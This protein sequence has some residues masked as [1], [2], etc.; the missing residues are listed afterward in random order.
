MSDKFFKGFT[1]I[2]LPIKAK[3]TKTEPEIEIVLSKK[4]TKSIEAI[5]SISFL[6]EIK[7]NG[8]SVTA[9]AGEVIEIPVLQT[10]GEVVRIL[11]VG[12][13][14]SSNSHIRKASAAIGRKIKASKSSVLSFLVGKDSDAQL[15]FIST[16]LATYIWSQ[17]SGTKSVTP[18]ITLVG[19]FADVLERSRVLVKS[20]W[21]ARDLIQTPANI[22]NPAWMAAQAKSLAKSPTLSLKIRSG[23]QLAEFGGLSAIGNSSAENPPRFVELSYKPKGSKRVPHV[24]L[25]GK[26]ITFDTGGVS[27]KRPYDVMTAMKSD[28]AGAACVLMA[29]IAAAE[30]KLDVRITALLMLAENALSGTSTRPSDVITHYGGTTVEVINTDAEGRL[31]LADGLAY[32]DKNL[33]PDYLIDVAT[34]TGAA[35]LGLSRYYGAM[36]TRDSKLARKLSD[37]GDY[38]GDQVWH[39]PL[40]DDYS[41]ALE[42]NIADFNHTADKFKFQGGSV[43]AALFLENFVGKRK[44]VHLDIAGPARSEV[45]AGE[46]VKGGTGYGVRLLTQWLAT[47]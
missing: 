5:F 46:N 2:A 25:V 21:K 47:L 44:W 37:I 8:G 16:A 29:T 27:L 38:T 20:T 12:V 43:T 4:I 3:E 28:M 6:D 45:D 36:Y 42:S 41:I 34:L 9:K 13:G 17:K 22:K 32:A 23:R 40:V 7:K 39:M 33:E 35:T 11:L 30:L 19:S 1:H 24:V 26:G 31:V 15:H 18:E 14:E 10:S